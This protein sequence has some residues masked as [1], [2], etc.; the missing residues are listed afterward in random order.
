MAEYVQILETVRY[1]GNK[2]KFLD[3]LATLKNPRP[4]EIIDTAFHNN[5]LLHWA[6]R[7][8]WTDVCQLLIEEYKV[9]THSRTSGGRTALHFAASE[10]NSA[11]CRLLV[12]R[13]NMD[14][15]IKSESGITTLHTAIY[16]GDGWTDTCE[17][18]V[19][20]YK[21]DPHCRD[22]NGWTALHYVAASVA[23]DKLSV[24]AS[25][26]L[27][28]KY[29]VNPYCKTIDGLTILHFACLL[30]KTNLI[31]YLITSVCC[32]PLAINNAGI[33]P[34]DLVIGCEQ[35][36]YIQKIIG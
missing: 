24:Q 17:L 16:G 2:E 1:P 12:E 4:S 27:V 14:P 6:A 9:S 28:E 18:L 20:K 7:N 31:E 33:T 23:D 22:V 21:V 25:R 11:L 29:K 13:Y 34:L 5:T 32:D 30:N 36:Q 15:H 3:L 35:K 10:D 8:G 19:E 26:V